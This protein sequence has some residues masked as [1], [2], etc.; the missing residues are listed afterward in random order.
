MKTTQLKIAIIG[1]GHWGPNLVR[2]FHEDNRIEVKTICDLDLKRANQVASKYPNIKVTSKIEDILI[3]SEIEAVIICT[4]TETHYQIAT[5]CLNNKKH[6]FIEKPLATS[7]EECNRLIS[8]AKQVDRKLMVGHIFLFNSAVNYVKGLLYRKELGDILYI[9]GK[10]LNLGPIRK[11][12]NAL[13]DLAPHD[14]AIFN[15]WLGDMPI[16]TQATGI[17]HVNPNV[18]DVVFV[19]LK[20]PN[21]ILANLHVS[22]LDPRSAAN[23][24]TPTFSWYLR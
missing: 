17:T 21:H 8:L 7:T 2:N 12:V 5:L 11:D 23:H 18:E 15:Y 20:Y 14:I 3:D 24:Q 10:R 13:W 19:S 4:P 6:V 9:Y 1:T 16:S 22:W